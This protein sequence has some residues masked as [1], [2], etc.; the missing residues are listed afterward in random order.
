MLSV[1]VNSYACGVPDT[2]Y[3]E[4]VTKGRERMHRDADAIQHV[5]SAGVRILPCVPASAAA[6]VGS[7]EAGVLAVLDREAV[8][9]SDDRRFL[10]LLARQGVP[11]LTPAQVIVLLASTGT[12]TKAEALRALQNFRPAIRPAVYQAAHEQLEGIEGTT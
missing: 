11:F 5:L 2:V 10:A 12:I 3:E 7:G 1:L 4:V 6:A 9:V 8:V